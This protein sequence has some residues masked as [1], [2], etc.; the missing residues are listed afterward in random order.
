MHSERVSV[1]EELAVGRIVVSRPVH[2]LLS[3]M[4][5]RAVDMSV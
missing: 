1:A 4:R 3:R 5:R 2:P